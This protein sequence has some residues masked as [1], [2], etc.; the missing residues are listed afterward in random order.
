VRP[1][2]GSRLAL[3]RIGVAWLAFIA[4]VMLAGGARAQTAPN[5]PNAPTAAGAT[6]RFALVVTNN[7]SAELGRPDLRYADDDGARYYETFRM[8]MPEDNV[9]LLTE[10][11]SDT[12]KLFPHLKDKTVPPDRAHVLAAARE[13]A[14][15][16]KEAAEHGATVEFTFVFAGHGD[17]DQGRGFLELTDGAFRSDDVEALLRSVPAKRS[18]VILDSCNSFFVINARKPGG[19][20]FAT[21]ADAARALSAR[22]PNV[23]VF[24]S[25]SAEAEVFEWSELQAGIFSHAVRSGL[26]GAADANGDHAISYAELRAF[27]ATAAAQV[28]NPA[29]RPQVFARGPGGRDSEVLFDLGDAAADRVELPATRDVRVT[30][31]DA[32]ELPWVDVHKESGAPATLYLPLRWGARANIDEHTSGPSGP[33]L[34]RASLDLAPG[35]TSIGL[36]SLEAST[37]P[38]AGRGPN[39]LFKMLFA[40]PFGPRAFAQYEREQRDEPP[41]VYGIS[42]DDRARMDLLLSQAAQSDRARRFIGG[43]AMLGIGGAELAIGLG[44]GSWPES[45]GS[46]LVT[47][48]LSL[49]GALFSFLMPGAGERLYDDYR[50]GLASS[51]RDPA[52]VIA[53]TERKLFELAETRRT[54]RIITGAMGGAFLLGGAALIGYGTWAQTSDTTRQANDLL[55]VLTVGFGAAV[56]GNALFPSPIEQIAEQWSLDPGLQRMPRVAP[57]PTLEPMVGLGGVGIRGTF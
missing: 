42:D 36:A 29:F 27:V 6:I 19:Q 45:R 52:L 37:A 30:V 49:G 47:G 33:A 2:V 43:L 7:R 8:V 20:H 9:F 34:R 31:R 46:Y 44:A 55:G 12:E 16:A 53:D 50:G 35:V 56:L 24:L 51:A 13:I 48:G 18:H 23:G 5:A 4:T 3:A 28:P 38:I 17:V 11:D 15:R 40:R 41:A 26:S 21:A 14:R 32:T 57:R 39:E 1:G 22:L 25:T 10:F 54:V